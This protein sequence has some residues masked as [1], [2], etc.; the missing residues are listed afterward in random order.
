M[1]TLKLS[2]GSVLKSI[3]LESLI[4]QLNQYDLDSDMELNEENKE[5]FE[6]FLLII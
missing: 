2:I 1:G 6:N 5:N 3:S 4:D